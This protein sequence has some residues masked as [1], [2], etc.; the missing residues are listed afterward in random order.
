MPSILIS[1]WRDVI[2]D[3]VPATLK[4]I[5]PK[6]SSSPKISESTENSLPSL[7]KPMAIPATGSL[8]GTPASISASDVPHTV[9][10]EDE[11][12]DSVISDTTLKVYGKF[13]GF[14]KDELIALHASLPCPTSL[15]PVPILPH[16][17]T[18]KG[19]KL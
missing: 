11:P 3:L 2:P 12:L 14:G 8:I 7:I 13:S 16:S 4:S 6:W 10:I 1:I 18:E 15:L 17:P 19:G 5:S 9:A